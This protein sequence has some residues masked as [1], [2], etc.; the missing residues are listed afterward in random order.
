[1]KIS[2]PVSV[3]A[4]S[5]LLLAAGATGAQEHRILDRP[6]ESFETGLA[7]RSNSEA[8]WL[9][10]D[11]VIITALAEADQEE[12]WKNPLT[13]VVLVNFRTRQIQVIAE[14]AAV[15]SF[16]QEKLTALIGPRD[17]TS[18]ARE[19][20]LGPF[21]FEAAG[22]EVDSVWIDRLIHGG[23]GRQV[24]RANHPERWHATVTLPS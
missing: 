24:E 2:L 7:I 18:D 17:R 21:L 22:S 11:Q 14:N 9:D 23:E 12:A 10:Q 20:C 15:M 13:R 6:V 1:M 3:V 4:S 19:V 16:D 5:L 8:E